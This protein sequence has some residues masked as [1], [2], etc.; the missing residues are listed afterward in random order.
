[1]TTQTN[2][3]KSLL[4][5]DVPPECDVYHKFCQS[6]NVCIRRSGYSRAQLADRMNYAS[7]NNYQVDETKLNKWFAPSQAVQMPVHLLSSLCWALQSI[8]PATIL[9]SPLLFL[10]VDKRAQMLQKHAELQMGIEAMKKDQQSILSELSQAAPDSPQ[11]EV[12]DFI[13]E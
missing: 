13:E 2:S 9:L 10:P 5:E 7:T 11:F 4:H 8:E 1:M 12:S 6:V 3:F